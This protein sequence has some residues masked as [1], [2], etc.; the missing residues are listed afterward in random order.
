MDEI[1]I[2]LV[3]TELTL[4]F[5]SQAGLNWSVT[6]LHAGVPQRSSYSQTP[7]LLKN[8]L[9]SAYIQLFILHFFLPFEL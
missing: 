2:H 4:F 5:I 3:T 6:Q 8:F 9:I 7:L 1:I